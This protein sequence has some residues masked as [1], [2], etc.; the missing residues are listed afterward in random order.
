[1]AGATTHEALLERPQ[2]AGS[3]DRHNFWHIPF[4]VLI[5]RDAD[6]IYLA[7]TGEVLIP[8]CRRTVVMPGVQADTVPENAAPG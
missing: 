4:Q 2:R 7:T 6:G 8:E 5:G 1:M 3:G